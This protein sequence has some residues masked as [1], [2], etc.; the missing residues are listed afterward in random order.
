MLRRLYS[1]LF[2]ARHRR[3]A[4]DKLRTLERKLPSPE[5]RFAVPFVFRGRGHFRSMKAIQTPEEI[6][7]LY[8][9][10]LGLA[11]RRVLEIGTLRGGTLY[12]FCRAALPD[13]TIVTVDLE[14]GRFGGGY[15]ECKSP[16]YEAFAGP[17]QRLHLVRGDSHARET[18]EQVKGILGS[19]LP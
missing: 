19:E 11:P 3:A 2:A 5:A 16:F 10:V 12:L 7:T 1:D 18:L 6:E 8:R 4:I 17:R 15:P 9:R 13:A 14:G